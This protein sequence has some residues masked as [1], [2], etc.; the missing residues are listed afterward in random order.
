MLVLVDTSSGW[1]E[2]FPCQTNKSKEVVKIIL[3]EIIPRFGVQEGISSDNG[4]YFI[5]E[6][7]QEIATVLKFKWDFKG[8]QDLFSK[9]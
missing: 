9:P 3:K 5:A 1:P 4:P 6:I 2:A 7:V 8:Q